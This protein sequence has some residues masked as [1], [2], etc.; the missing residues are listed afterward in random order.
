MKLRGLIAL[1]SLACLPAVAA[2]RRTAALDAAALDAASAAPSTTPQAAASATAAAAS[3]G[4]AADEPAPRAQDGDKPTRGPDG[5]KRR[6]V[7]GQ[8]APE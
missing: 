2:C 7:R 4:G 3:Q 6:V 8:H 1:L 5:R